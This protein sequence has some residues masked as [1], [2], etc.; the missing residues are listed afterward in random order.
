MSSPLSKSAQTSLRSWM[1]D[2]M[3]DCNSFLTSCSWGCM[4]LWAGVH[5]LELRLMILQIKILQKGNLYRW[6][7]IVWYAFKH[8]KPFKLVKN[9]KLWLDFLHNM[10]VHMLQCLAFP[11]HITSSRYLDPKIANILFIIYI[12]NFPVVL[13]R[14]PWKIGICGPS[15]AVSAPKWSSP[16]LAG[17]T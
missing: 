7:L 6:A 11:N 16:K 3:A 13:C 10:H 5:L 17:K 12:L 15:F 9:D 4:L 14:C 2:C 8:L 1:H